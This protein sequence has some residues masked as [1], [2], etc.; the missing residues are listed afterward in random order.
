MTDQNTRDEKSVLIGKKL[1]DYELV[2]MLASGGMARIYVGMDTKLQRR[3]AV[4]VLMRELME[5]D[6]TLT[7]R[8][9]REARAVAAL[10]HDNIVPIYQFGEYEGLYFLAMR[11]IDGRDLADQISDLR[12][13]GKRMDP[14]RALKILLQIASALDYAHTAG[15]IHRDIK[16]SNILIDRN[17]KAYLTDFGLVLRQSV[18]KT[19]GTAFGTP[20]YISPEQALAS[21][22]SVPQSDIYS[23]AVVLYEILTG[24][25]LFRADTPMQIA[26]SHI[27]EPPP[28]PRSV[29]P[30]I[31]ESVERELLKALSKDPIRRH[32]T[33]T[34]FINA[35][36]SA[37]GSDLEETEGIVPMSGGQPGGVKTLFF[38]ENRQ[39]VRPSIEKPGPSAKSPAQS[40]PPTVT[41]PARTTNVVPLVAVAAIAIV[42][43]IAVVA[44]LPGLNAGSGTGTPGS[45][46]ATPRNTIQATTAASDGTS[47][48]A[49][50]AT[51]PPTDTQAAEP[52]TPTTAAEVQPTTMPTSVP[53]VPSGDGLPVRIAYDDT[54]LVLRNE[55]AFT[56]N[57]STLVLARSA[58]ATGFADQI[59][60]NIIPPGE[61][62][63][64]LR[65]S[66]NFSA[67]EWRC[68]GLVHTQVSVIPADAFWRQQGSEQIFEVRSGSEVLADCP[69]A[70]RGSNRL[71][72]AF[73]LPANLAQAQ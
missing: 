52:A 22:K 39:P 46:P 7:E 20:R 40:E 71:E 30:N 59:N 24:D 10:E 27:S 70:A 34:E 23:L 9:Q 15:I 21:E 55:S 3:A 12:K 45:T 61:C 13:E 69:V 36:R 43:L 35:V 6:E 64:I 65:G 44:I 17:G 1:G 51:I 16:P 14:A 73:N 54:I 11:F 8:F 48:A 57:A 41:P 2:E 19:M 68:T 63:V 38:D 33:A 53:L 47:V 25:M 28:P 72:C 32:R 50:N 49:A 60:G 5:M 42:A 58:A 37:Y 56:I 26:L 4:K 67:P 18:D 31:P 29:N 66:V 62:V